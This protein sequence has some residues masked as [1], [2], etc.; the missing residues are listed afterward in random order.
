MGVPPPPPVAN[1]HIA[2]SIDENWSE[3]SAKTWREWLHR[4]PKHL[5][6][7]WTSVQI[8]LTSTNAIAEDKMIERQYCSALFPFNTPR[9]SQVEQ[10]TCWGRLLQA[11]ERKGL[12]L[13]WQRTI[14]ANTTTSS[15]A[16]QTRPQNSVNPSS[17]YIHMQILQTNLHIHLLKK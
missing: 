4:V 12:R 16:K 14:P 10:G 9:V 6:V 2:V 3:K 15:R 17:R 8:F 7:S 1:K 11:R 5:R 13:T